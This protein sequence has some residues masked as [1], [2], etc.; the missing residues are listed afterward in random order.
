[1]C[2]ACVEEQEYKL[3]AIAGLEVIVIADML[4]DLIIFYEEMGLPEEIIMLL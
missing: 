2:V 3:A 4:E 1:M